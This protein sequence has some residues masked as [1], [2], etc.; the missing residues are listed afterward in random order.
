MADIK[1]QDITLSDWTKGISADEFAWGSYFYSDGIQTWYSTKWF[2]LWPYLDVENLNERTTGYP[3]AVCP[4]KW[5]PS[6]STNS[7]IFFTKDW[8]L[9]MTWTF[10]WST[11]WDWGTDWGWAIY[12]EYSWSNLQWTWWFVYWDYALAFVDNFIHKIEYNNTYKLYWQSI[13]NPRFENSAAGWTV[14]T[15]WTLTDNWMEHTTWETGT[16]SVSANGYDTASM[17]RLAVKIVDCTKGYV[18][19]SIDN[20]DSDSFS[21]EEWR[22]WWFVEWATSISDS[23]TYTITI[24]PTSDFNWTVEALN[25]GTYNSSALSIISSLTDADRHIAIER[26][27]DI[28]I[29]WGNTVDILSTI[30]WTISDS[31][32]L[33]RADEEIIAMT[34]QWDSLILRATNWIDSHQYYRNWVDSA[35]TECIAWKWQVIK[36]VTWTETV[37]YVLAWVG[38]SSAGYAYRLYSVSGYQRSLIASNAYKVQGN[39]RNLEHYHPSKKFVFNDTET[40]ESMCIF[41]DN[42]YLPGCDGIYQFWQTIPWLSNAWSRPINYQNWADK[43]FLYQDWAS[44]G[45]SYRYKQMT[46]YVNVVNE[47]YQDH[48][49]IV[50]DS[51]YRDKIGTRKAIEKLKLGYKSIPVEFWNIKIYAIVDDDYFWRFDVTWITNRPAIWDKYEVAVWT[52]AEIIKI[53]KKNSSSWEITFRT[54]TNE[55]SLSRADNTLSKVSWSGDNS[56]TTNQNYDNMCLIKTIETTYQEYGSD[57]IFWKDF[58]NN[59]MPYRHKL[60]L[61]IELNKVWWWA[62][63]TYRTPEIYELS[64]VSDI[65]DVTL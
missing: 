43:L 54:V 4:C 57:L 1:R 36:A 45:F 9:E 52:V 30:D 3:I 47:R 63:N 64:M 22:D 21:T 56:L 27:W 61:V 18:T 55:W 40:S 53:N 50:T 13:T 16:L 33:V 44:L 60:Q 6:S 11:A 38:G 7:V 42:L 41:M 49:Y 51:L 25:F 24:T 62:T 35:P 34:Q 17:W 48:W 5:N 59:Y 20:S 46:Y 8:R 37:S 23:T 32:E 65:T 10:N 2:K 15:W 12:N 29:A 58:V 26:G 31:K 39:S 19:V 28:F 14:G